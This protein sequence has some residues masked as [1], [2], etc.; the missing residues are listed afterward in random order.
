MFVPIRRLEELCRAILLL[1]HPPTRLDFIFKHFLSSFWH[2][3][4]SKQAAGSASTFTRKRFIWSA[5][6]LAAGDFACEF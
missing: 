5:K 3:F 4:K 1:H 6:R 2:S